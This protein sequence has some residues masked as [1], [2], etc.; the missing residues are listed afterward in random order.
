MDTRRSVGRLVLAG[1]AFAGVILGH[2]LSY[3]IA[4]PD[5]HQRTVALASAGHGYWVSAV[6][7]AVTCAVVAVASEAIRRTRAALG[8]DSAPEVGPSG[9][10]VRLATLQV[11]G[12]VAMEVSELVTA[13]APVASVFQHHLFV[14]GILIQLLVAA[15]VALTLFLVGRAAVAIVVALATRRSRPPSPH[16]FPARSWIAVQRW[17]VA[18]SGPRGPPSR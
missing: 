16:G 17:A 13:G 7:L 9:L 12:F 1:A 3:L 2:W 5:A 6:K 11:L 15:V 10:A 4:L 8:R 18:A 14:L